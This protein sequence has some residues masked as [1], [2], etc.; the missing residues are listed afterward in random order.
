MVIL[1]LDNFSFWGVV[2]IEVVFFE[3][4]TLVGFY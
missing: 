2:S 4:N 3:V 1:I